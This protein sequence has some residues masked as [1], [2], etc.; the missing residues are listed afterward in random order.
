MDWFSNRYERDTEELRRQRREMESIS[1]DVNTLKRNNEALQS[2]I[3]EKDEMNRRFQE[4]IR[5]RDRAREEQIYRQ[6]QMAMKN[7]EAQEEIKNELRKI[8]KRKDE[9]AK[10]EKDE[11]KRKQQQ[12]KE[13]RKKIDEEE[14]AKNKKNEEFSF[15]INKVEQKI[16]Q[17]KRTIKELIGEDSNRNKINSLL[18]DIDSDVVAYQN[19]I[20]QK[21]N[22][23]S[24]ILFNLHDV[25]CYGYEKIADFF[26][27]IKEYNE[28]VEL[29]KKV[30]QFDSR[31]KRSKLFN[32]KIG[33]T[34]FYNSQYSE[35]I[36]YFN[37][38]K[39]N[40]NRNNFNNVKQDINI[41]CFEAYLKIEDSENAGNCLEE[42]INNID[43][44]KSRIFDFLELYFEYIQYKPS[45]KDFVKYF[46]Y[47]IALT[48]S[49]SDLKEKLDSVKFK[50][51]PFY[52]AYYEYRL[53]NY[54]ESLHILENLRGS[55]A[56]I[57]LFYYK[58]LSKAEKTIDS[59]ENINN[60]LPSL[61]NL[62]PGKKYNER[63]KFLKDN[64]NLLYLD[65]S[66]SKNFM[67]FYENLMSL[68]LKYYLNNSDYENLM[69]SAK[70]LKQV[71]FD[72]DYAPALQIKII[73][74]EL[75]SFFNNNNSEN[76]EWL[77]DFLKQSTTDKELENLLNRKYKDEKSFDEKYQFFNEKI[78]FIE[79]PFYF[80]IK[81]V[82]KISDSKCFVLETYR[83][84]LSKENK[85]KREAALYKEKI[86]GEKY[87]N[88]VTIFDYEIGEEVT[89]VA[90]PK[91]KTSL[92]NYLKEKILSDEEKSKLAKGVLD[93]FKNL[94]KESIILSSLN[95]DKIVLDYNNTPILRDTFF[96]ESFKSE[97]Q[98]SMA[99]SRISSSNRYKV[100]DEKSDRS[101]KSNTYLLGLLL[102]EIFYEEYIF[103]DIKDFAT[104]TRLH[105]EALVSRDQVTSLRERWIVE[106]E[107]GTNVR[108]EKV[109]ESNDDNISLE[110]KSILKKMLSVDINK[111]PSLNQIASSIRSF[112]NDPQKEIER[113]SIINQEI[114]SKKKLKENI[115][116]MKI[117][118]IIVKNQSFLNEL[119][120]TDNIEITH[121]NTIN[122]DIKI[123]GNSKILGI[124]KYGMKYNVEIVQT[125]RGNQDK[126]ETVKDTLEKVEKAL[127]TE[128]N[129][130][131]A[132]FLFQT[133]NILYE[134]ENGKDIQDLIDEDYLHLAKL[135]KVEGLVASNTTNDEFCEII[136]NSLI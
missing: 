119:I 124:V 65:C 4:E 136:N 13:E 58:V 127:I 95:P 10:R 131:F 6:N 31:N 109:N 28:S 73:F 89:K 2:A 74:S 84:N 81:A 118:S 75:Y 72:Y 53:F 107:D 12:L 16:K 32:F 77:Y 115:S 48:K 76:S 37:K 21:S 91:F 129:E 110:Y 125:S 23:D 5:R 14:F 66:T 34:F 63:S 50:H 59:L 62:L 24:N 60:I 49:N 93:I 30:E 29:Y 70:E 1:R 106:R 104:I 45:E 105:K 101:F 121:D 67:D 113:T 54:N 86:L 44:Y 123:I 130:N 69:I 68:K 52:E 17:Y 8:R 102:Y 98:S 96:D 103:G 94:E 99:S 57:D 132:D 15:F 97:S 9:E 82:N 120:E 111:R 3:R 114:M 88:F 83:E 87:N 25:I 36:K 85:V 100:P 20:T 41:I 79:N 26:F 112:E 122:F 51:K 90:Y 78:D 43:E 128:K 134:M 19:I 61:K 116:N 33:R 11:L 55:N 117:T 80:T 46:S 135:N 42:I 108:V 64:G 27:E 92:T 47:N 40:A 126:K 18:S 71:L 35:S 56:L 38:F 22:I 7:Q 133:R 39:E